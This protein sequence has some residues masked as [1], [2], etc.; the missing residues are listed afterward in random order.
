VR[1]YNALTPPLL[2]RLLVA[3]VVI[4]DA[5]QTIETSSTS[6]DSTS[7]ING[8]KHRLVRDIGKGL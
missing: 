8:L 3:K 5:M 7:P 6:A 2:N 4:L 1:V